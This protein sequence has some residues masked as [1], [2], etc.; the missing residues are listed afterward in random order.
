VLALF[1]GVALMNISAGNVNAQQNQVQRTVLLRTDDPAGAG[2][3][4]MTVVVSMPSEASTG[5]H[6]HHGV[7]TGYV[8]EGTPTLEIQ[9]NRRGR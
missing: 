8:L 4:I 1:V 2:Y 6:Y 7:E 9:G 3:E 5:R